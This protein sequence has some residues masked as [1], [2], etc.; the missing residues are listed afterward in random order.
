MAE[1]NTNSDTRKTIR[2]LNLQNDTARI[3]VCAS[4]AE[5][6]RSMYT[7][8]WSTFTKYWIKCQNKVREKSRECHDYKQQLF[9]DTKRKRKPTNPNK[10]KSIKRM[11]RSKGLGS[12]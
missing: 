1:S 5:R 11:K 9:P 12:D 2:S 4:L 8:I 6:T 3:V 10:H 7:A